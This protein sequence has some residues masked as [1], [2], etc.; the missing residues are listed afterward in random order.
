MLREQS[1][2]G[3]GCWF[4]VPSGSMPH[5]MS[6]SYDWLDSVKFQQNSFYFGLSSIS[7]I[8]RSSTRRLRAR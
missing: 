6:A 2:V 4:S 8:A 5:G 7:S 3:T 1:C